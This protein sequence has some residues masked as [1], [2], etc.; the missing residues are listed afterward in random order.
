MAH[1]SGTKH[2]ADSPCPSAAGRLTIPSDSLGVLYTIAVLTR[3]ETE[4]AFKPFIQMALIIK[5]GLEG[6][7]C[8]GMAFFQELLCFLY[9]D[10]HM[11]SVG[12]KPYGFAEC[13]YE[14]I[15]T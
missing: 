12:G 2:A 6:Y 8:D 7:I 14:V 3:G 4:K 15:G 1:D 5:S 9:P 10:L 11:I 13:P